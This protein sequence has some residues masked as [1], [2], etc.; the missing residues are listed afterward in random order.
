LAEKI[1]FLFF[2][3][4]DEIEVFF[5]RSIDQIQNQYFY[6]YTYR[7]QG[8]KVLRKII[9]TNKNDNIVVALTPKGLHDWYY[10]LIKKSGAIVFELKDTPK[11]I[12]DR[13]VFYDEDS[14]LIEKDLSEDDKLYYLSE[15]KKDI[16]YYR[17]FY[18]RAHYHVD[19]T[20]LD[21]E[22]SAM[23]LERLIEE[24]IIDRSRISSQ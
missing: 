20:G 10:R 8:A 13:I 3:L 5:G 11:N 7:E 22:G 17:K 1:D 19:I 21:V 23:K 14:N 2:N 16:S 15:I 12:L 4:D 6:G 18:K 24:D 9:D